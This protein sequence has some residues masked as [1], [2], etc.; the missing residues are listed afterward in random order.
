MSVNSIRKHCTDEEVISLA[1][2]LIK[3]WKRLLGTQIVGS[4]SSR[5]LF[6][7]CLTVGWCS[8]HRLWANS[9]WKI[10]WSGEWFGLQQKVFRIQQPL[11]RDTRQVSISAG[12]SADSWVPLIWSISDRRMK[13]F[14][15]LHT[16]TKR[17]EWQTLQNTFIEKCCFY[18]LKFLT[19]SG[20]WRFLSISLAVYNDRVDSDHNIF[21]QVKFSNSYFFSG[22]KH[23]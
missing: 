21:L 14:Q 7:P 22:S 17:A 15:A 2:L 19:L 11:P 5:A 1:K 8:P 13:K 12:T 16:S 20:L 4:R 9:V 6:V 10:F 23:T 3:D 18:L